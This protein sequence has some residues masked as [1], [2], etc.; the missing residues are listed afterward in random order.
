MLDIPIDEVLVN[1]S[2]FKLDDDVFETFKR[3]IS[4]M[5]NGTT[6]DLA[7]TDPTVKHILSAKFDELATEVINRVSFDDIFMTCYREYTRKRE[8]H[9]KIIADARKSY[10]ENAGII[11][12]IRVTP[13]P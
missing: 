4:K 3:E 12:I 2:S 5:S 13:D 7:T 1:Q 6:T 10:M 9:L 11:G 8:E